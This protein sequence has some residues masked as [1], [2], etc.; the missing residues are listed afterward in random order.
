MIPLF[1]LKLF[2]RDAES[3]AK[4]AGLAAWRQE[5]YAA[6]SLLPDDVPWKDPSKWT[7][8]PVS[9]DL[10]LIVAMQAVDLHYQMLAHHKAVYAYLKSNETLRQAALEALAAL[11]FK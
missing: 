6:I 1:I 2:G 4:K 8:D 9:H 3:V 5:C 7:L 11:T 10:F